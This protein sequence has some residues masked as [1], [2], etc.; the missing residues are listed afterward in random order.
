MIDSDRPCLSTGGVNKDDGDSV[1]G[2]TGMEEV[3]R[4]DRQ[5]CDV[6][7]TH[8]N[9]LKESLLGQLRHTARHMNKG[10]G[11][12]NV[13][14][15]GDSGGGGMVVQ[16]TQQQQQVQTQQQQNELHSNIL[17]GKRSN[18][19]S[20]CINNTSSSLLIP[21]GISSTQ[22]SVISSFNAR[23]THPPLF[24]LELPHSHTLPPV[25][26]PS[27]LSPQKPSSYAHY[28][29]TSAAID[30]R[31]PPLHPYLSYTVP[32]LAS[33]SSS[34]SSSS[35]SAFSSVCLG[36]LSQPISS[37]PDVFVHKT[38]TIHL[39]TQSTSHRQ[40]QHNS[41]EKVYNTKNS[42]YCDRS[43]IAEGRDS[44]YN[45]RY[46]AGVRRD[47]RRASAHSSTNAVGGSTVSSSVTTDSIYMSEDSRGLLCYGYLQEKRTVGMRKQ[48]SCCSIE[49]GEVGQHVAELRKNKHDGD[50]GWCTMDVNN[51]I[52]EVQRQTEQGQRGRW[53]SSNRGTHLVEAAAAS[54]SCIDHKTHGIQQQKQMKQSTQQVQM[55]QQQQQKQYQ[56][57]MYQKQYSHYQQY[58]HRQQ[59][60]RQAVAGAVLVTQPQTRACEDALKQKKKKKNIDEE[61][62]SSQDCINEANGKREIKDIRQIES[63]C[64]GHEKSLMLL[65]IQH[66]LLS[67]ANQRLTHSAGCVEHEKALGSG[68]GHTDTEQP[69]IMTER[70]TPMREYDNHMRNLSASRDGCNRGYKPLHVQHRDRCGR[71]T[72]D[73]LRRLHSVH[74]MS[75]RNCLLPAVCA[76]MKGSANGGGGGGSCHGTQ[77]RTS[78]VS[79]VGGS[80]GDMRK[81]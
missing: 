8:S 12:E 68:G 23:V 2:R 26:V 31:L 58:H 34:S 37:S 13:N 45:Q 4:V 52:D 43:S 73:S 64:D 60:L 11:G 51:S 41:P 21:S 33:T 48:G 61:E 20:S 14:I 49:T 56:Q 32:R 27:S 35:S 25:L 42:V 15:R 1:C 79:T 18:N 62:G 57:G 72:R 78:D 24:S 77:R 67:K 70:V 6:I 65:D 53:V 5:V 55:Q 69:T 54:V 81:C 30:H 66:M 47:E 3:E 71:F 19:L 50:D 39:Q 17:L 63:E 22:T 59:Q 16:E 10:G 44:S 7:K 46:G 76:D 9:E 38:S 29:T 75:Q 80:F 74:S 40:Q 28:R 36:G